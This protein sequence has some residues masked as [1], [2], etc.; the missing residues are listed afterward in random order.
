[1]VNDDDVEKYEASRKRQRSIPSPLTHSKV[2]RALQDVGSGYEAD[3]SSETLE[4]DR[5]RRLGSPL[6]LK[7][8]TRQR[9]QRTRVSSPRMSFSRVLRYGSP[10]PSSSEVESR[11]VKEEE[12]SESEYRSATPSEAESGGVKEE[13]RSEDED[14]SATP[15]EVESE[16]VK[17]EEQSE[18]GRRSAAPSDV[19][20]RAAKEEEQSESEYCSATPSEAES[21]GVKE[22]RSESECRLATPS[23]AESEGFKEEER[24]ED[25]YCSATPSEAESGRVKEEERSEDEGSSATP[26]EAESGGIKEE[27]RSEDGYRS[28]ASS[29]VESGGVKEEERSESGRRSAAASAAQPQGFEIWNDADDS[30]EAGDSAADESSAG[31]SDKENNKSHRVPFAY[32]QHGEYAWVT[33]YLPPLNNAMSAA[34]DAGTSMA[35]PVFTAKYLEDSEEEETE[36]ESMAR[37][38]DLTEEDPEIK[39]EEEREGSSRALAIDLT[40]EDSRSESSY[41]AGPAK[42]VP[43]QAI[44]IDDI[45]DYTLRSRVRQVIDIIPDCAVGAARDALVYTRFSVNDALELLSVITGQSQDSLLGPCQGQSPESR[46]SSPSLEIENKYDPESRETESANDDRSPLVDSNEGSAEGSFFDEALWTSNNC[47]EFV[48]DRY[49]PYALETPGRNPFQ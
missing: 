24:S 15:S 19:E 32:L 26:S 43:V 1:M 42:A 38:I 8:L 45:E 16:E 6:Q 27:E 22:E 29:D 48:D 30:D 7:P 49:Q 39:E 20:S 46:S 11:G 4:G 47:V 14:H 37:P 17:E 31:P 2:L 33:N 3:R 35:G 23:E 13:E 18:G 9:G 10:S 34:R 12:Q 40:H 44:T 28:A 36:G 21:G 41:H 5:I 25:G